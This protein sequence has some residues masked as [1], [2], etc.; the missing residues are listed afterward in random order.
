[1]RSGSLLLILAFGCSEYTITEKPGVNDNPDS[2]EVEADSGVSTEPTND[3]E[4]DTFDDPVTEGNPPVAVCDVSP[5]PVH[6]PFEAATWDGTGSYDPDGG[7]LSYYWELI[8]SP[9]GTTATLSSPSSPTVSGFTPDLAGNY[10]AR[11]IVTNES[12]LEDSCEATLEAVPTQNL[13]VEMYW[14][15]ADD[16]MDLHLIAPNQNWQNAKESDYD[17][18]YANCAG[19]WS[20]L[21]WGTFGDSSDDPRLDL[22]DI[23]GTGPENI[24][25]DAPEESGAYTVL[26]HDYP[27]TGTYSG[28]NNVTVNIYLGGNLVWTDTR[29]ISGEDTYTVFAKVDWGNGVVIPQ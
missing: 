17:C 16:D 7:Q 1:M 19:S 13:W 27:Y 23:P 20:L 9:E 28:A 24:N 4:E 25:I 12:N 5:N 29:P 15:H 26:V 6:P 21:D 14:E 22:D 2:G 8:D 11:L 10:T 3:E 18:Y